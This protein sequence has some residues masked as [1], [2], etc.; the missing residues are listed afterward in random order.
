M[1]IIWIFKDKSLFKQLLYLSLT[2]IP[3]LFILIIQTKIMFPDRTGEALAIRPFIYMNFHY[4]MHHYPTI[5]VFISTVI[6]SFLFP[7]AALPLLWKHI[8]E[9]GNY[10]YVWVFAVVALLEAVLV[11]E[12]GWRQYH[13]F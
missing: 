12:L 4:N 11:V 7:L 6:Q 10:T 13:G 9:M 5:L 3:T 1:I 2:I 8:K